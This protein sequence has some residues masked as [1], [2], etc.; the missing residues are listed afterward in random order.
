MFRFDPYSYE[1]HEDPYPTYR[2]LRDEAPAYFDE[3]L[4]FWALS[5]HADVRGAVHDWQ[6]FTSAQGITLESTE[7]ATEPMIIEMD[8]P[9]HTQLRGLV[10]RAFT[11]RRISA[12]EEPCR[13]LA[14]K[15]ADRFVSTGRCDA[16]EDFAA[17]LP[18]AVISWM[19]DVPDADQDQ[20]RAWSDA[21]L[22]REPGNPNVTPAGI[23]GATNLFV[24][25][26]QLVS[27]RREHRGD[28]LVSV[29]IE[30]ED[31][32]ERLTHNE[33]LGFCFLLII[34]GN[35]TTTKLI[36]N[37]LHSLA[38]FP[39][40]RARLLADRSL[41]ASAVEETLRFDGSTQAMARTLTRD[42]E[43]HGQTM[44]A[45][46]KVLLLFGAA[47]RDERFWGPSVDTFDLDRDTTGQ[48]ALGHGIH[49]C[50][51]A[52]I[53]RLEARVALE[54]LLWRLPDYEVVEAG[55]ER[56]HSG[57]VR[58]FSRLPLEFTPTS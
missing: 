11:P 46:R 54:E 39:D 5:R 17:I 51:G 21:M 40:Q 19:L 27:E 47:N 31:D 35:E 7:D 33:V 44:E 9:R 24:Y 26:D 10:S 36:G 23:E 8:P 29:L 41:V 38:R 22:H 20:L 43:L 2:H 25:F 32:G 3:D 34:A 15:L 49:F 37:A 28:D 53:A 16:I 14:R 30:A 56:V 1:H 52:A 13:S 6:T 4:E 57:N 12:L 48:L 42:V 18:M 58:G 45:G 50:L 55:L